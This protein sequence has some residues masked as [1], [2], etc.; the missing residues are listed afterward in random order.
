MGLRQQSLV[1]RSHRFWHVVFFAVV[2]GILFVVLRGLGPVLTPV[3]AALVLAYLLDPVVSAMDRRLRLPR[4]AGTL[5]L[6]VLTVLV[7]ALG[8]LLLAPVLVHEI[9]AFREAVPGYVDKISDTLIPWA[10]RTFN[11]NVPD[12]FRDLYERWGSDARN[13]ATKVLG[14]LGG[15]AGK[16]VKRTAGVF[17][18]IAS[19]GLVPVFTFYFLPNFPQLIAG[20]RELIPYRYRPWV[21]D[22]AAEIDRALASWIRGQIT[23][24]ICLA[25]LYAVGLSIV[26]I[27]MAV[28]IGLLTG[29]L[30]FIPYVGFVIGLAFALLVCMLEYH[31]PGQLV[32][33]G[34]VYGSVQMLDGVFLTPRIVGDKA[35]IGPVGVLLALMLGGHL[36]GFVGVLLAVPVAAASAVVIKRM[37][38]A[39]RQSLFFRKGAEDLLR[40][41]QLVDAPHGELPAS[42]RSAAAGRDGADPDKTETGS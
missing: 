28:L 32:G 23:V 5:L 19:L 9:N 4:W 39:Y 10:E 7:V 37:L 1:R 12:N 18:T 8:I 21:D 29:F 24:I 6:F 35:G 36:F 31:G 14:P 25:T 3:A 33:V 17:S 15:V 16:V 27:K 38:A 42:R 2:L 22:T 34:I 40:A 41:G 30:A 11:L 26:G 13:V 20:G